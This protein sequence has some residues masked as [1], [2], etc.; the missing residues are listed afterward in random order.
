MLALVV[1]IDCACPHEVLDC[2][3]II[4]RIWKSTRIDEASCALPHAL[5][6]EQAPE[7]LADL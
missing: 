6:C 4:G 5:H 2:H 3:V 7:S 1:L